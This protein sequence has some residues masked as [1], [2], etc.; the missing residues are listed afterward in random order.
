[1]ILANFQQLLGL[2]K[3]YYVPGKPVTWVNISRYLVLGVTDSGDLKLD[4]V[5][6]LNSLSDNMVGFTT[7]VA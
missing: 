5:R 7:D 3:N 1:M 2:F 6:S 4:S